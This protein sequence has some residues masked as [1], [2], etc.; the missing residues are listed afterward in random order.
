MP[1]DDKAIPLWDKTFIDRWRNAIKREF[2]SGKVAAHRLAAAGLNPTTVQ[3]WLT[4]GG[5]P[6]IANLCLVARA[7]RDPSSFMVE[8]CGDE[9]WALELGVAVQRRRL[10]SAEDLLRRR[11]DAIDGPSG[12]LRGLA[13]PGTS[14]RFVTDSGVMTQPAACP[15]QIA[16]ALLGPDETWS[17]RRASPLG[18]GLG[19]LVETVL[20]ALGWI[21]LE[22]A[23][24]QPLV[25]RCHAVR[26]SDRATAMLSRW[27][28]QAP[29]PGGVVVCSFLAGWVEMPCASSYQVA[30]EL[31]RLRRV[32]DYA[33]GRHDGGAAAIRAERLALSDA[34]PEATAIHRL[35]SEAGGI[36][37]PAFMGALDQQ[38][39]VE[40]CGIYGVR[41]GRFEVTYLGSRLRMP[42]GLTRETALGRDLLDIQPERGFGA[43][44][45]AHSSVCAHERRPIVHRVQPAPGRDYRR[46]AL[47]LFDPSG[48]RVVAVMGV[49]DARVA[50]EQP[51][52]VTRV[53]KP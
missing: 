4:R 38:S 45:A 11:A 27:L 49:S 41:D 9:P 22:Q 46:L 43:M 3:S 47:P 36:L 52:T 44:V 39:G 53:G 23:E 13:G 33:Q 21:L 19:P 18:S 6:T 48:R 2:G 35:W 29:T 10:R 1:S 30:A 16:H 24:G 7:A 34:P 14:Y 20:A 50:N 26:V 37:D 51:D 8:V 15:E 17:D 32:R 28:E 5:R 42:D 40:T 25:I 12:V 31:A